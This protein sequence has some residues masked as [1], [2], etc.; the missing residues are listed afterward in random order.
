MRDLSK[1]LELIKEFEGFE[2]RP[3]LCS[4]RVPTIGIGTTVYPDGKKV[5]LKDS[6]ITLEK[7]Y[8]YLLV[9]VAKDRK[10]IDSFLNT[11]KIT[12][13]DFQYSA[14]VVFAYNLGTGPIITK[15]RSLHEALKTRSNLKVTQALRLYNKAAVNGKLVV[16]KGLSR[17]R[18]AEAALYCS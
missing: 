1:A 15:G 8:E 2:P 6:P 3:Y 9:H 11:N 16:L 5:T 4:A 13:N 12:L 18:D 7:A 14:L 17:R 10:Q